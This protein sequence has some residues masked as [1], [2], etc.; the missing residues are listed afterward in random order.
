MKQIIKYKVKL[1][2]S[3]INLNLDLRYFIKPIKKIEP[4]Q[5]KINIKKL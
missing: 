1:S 2:L 3:L 5:K 4:G